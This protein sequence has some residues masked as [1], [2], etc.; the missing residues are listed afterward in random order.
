MKRTENTGFDASRP[1]TVGKAGTLVPPWGTRAASA[2]LESRT[3]VGFAISSVAL[4]RDMGWVAETGLERPAYS[5]MPLRGNENV[6]TPG[7]PRF[8]EGST[9]MFY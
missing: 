8:I 2:A 5:Q 3:P 7:T 1:L 6:Q 4:R 9:T